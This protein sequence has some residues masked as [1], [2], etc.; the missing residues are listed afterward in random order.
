MR[1]EFFVKKTGILVDSKTGPQSWAS[2]RFLIMGGN[3]YEISFDTY[4]SQSSV[5]GF[6]DFV[7]LRSDIGW[8]V[9]D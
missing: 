7:D 2:D 5:I 3:V 8:R 4:E 9:V 1:I 6:D